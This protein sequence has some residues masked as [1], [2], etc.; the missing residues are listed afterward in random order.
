MRLDEIART[1][2][3][4]KTGWEDSKGKNMGSGVQGYATMHPTQQNVV[5]KTADVYNVDEDAYVEFVK[6]ALEHQDNPF[7]PKIYKAKLVR[8][9]EFFHRLVITMERLHDIS[10]PKI[11]D[12]IVANFRRLGIP[13]DVADTTT[14]TD[15]IKVIA[16]RALL[17]D[18]IYRQH[19]AKVTPNPKFRE[20]LTLLDPYI[21]KFVNDLHAQ[22]WMARLTPSGP[23]L[24]IIDPIN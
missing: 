18:R 12:A 4:P 7:F 15:T 8:M 21:E 16:I 5:V 3:V 1:T 10:K 20:A 23:Q 13:Q 17:N 9:G 19:L 11:A 24:V 14:S 2:R 22:N 6:L